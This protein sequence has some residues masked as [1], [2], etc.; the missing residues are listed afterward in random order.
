MSSARAPFADLDDI[1]LSTQHLPLSFDGAVCDLSSAL[2]DLSACDHLRN[3]IAERGIP[4]PADVIVAGDPLEV[5]SYAADADRGLAIRLESELTQLEI[6]AAADATLTPHVHDVVNACRESGRS[7]AII[8][9]NAIRAVNLYLNAHDLAD[10][11]DNIIAREAA[12]LSDVRPTT[13][14]V[15]RTVTDLKAA[16]STCALVCTT[17]EAIEA[18]EISGAYSIAYA[19]TSSDHDRLASA[20]AG[21]IIT[22]LTHL[23]L[24]LRARNGSGG[25]L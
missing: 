21:T 14:L 9:Q 16:P 24:R 5:L 10:M 12:G 11:A 2:R 8:S 22:S 17:V 20:G 19:R 13:Q 23:A 3:T 4:L 1:L 25:H 6:R 18:A 7:V 15:E